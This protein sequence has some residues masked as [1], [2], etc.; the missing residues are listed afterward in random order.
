MMKNMKKAT[1]MGVALLGCLQV[2]AA[3]ANDYAKQYTQAYS[4]INDSIVANDK[5]AVAV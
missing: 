3:N 5:A 4:A 1:L 2:T